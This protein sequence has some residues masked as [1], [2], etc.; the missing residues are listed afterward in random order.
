MPFDARQRLV[1][2]RGIAV[3]D[4]VRMASKAKKK[5][6][7]PG[8]KPDIPGDAVPDPQERTNHLLAKSREKMDQHHE[9]MN[10]YH[11]LDSPSL[12]NQNAVVVDSHMKFNDDEYLSSAHS[13]SPRGTIHLDGFAV[14][15]D[16]S[17]FFSPIN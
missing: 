14:D 3:L 9:A 12:G 17:E 11:A 7:K 15:E 16:K 6:F 4:S 5:S 2:A 8:W 10:R 1:P 13:L